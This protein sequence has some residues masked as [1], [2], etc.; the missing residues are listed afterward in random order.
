MEVT[1]TTENNNQSLDDVCVYNAKQY[2]DEFVGLK[3]EN[4][5]LTVQFPYGYRK[6]ESQKE[7]RKDILN[8]I[9]VLSSFSA[10]RDS[11]Y[12]EGNNS[13]KLKQFPIHSY[14]HIITSFMN[15]GYYKETEIVYKKNNTGKIS[16]N[17]TIKSVT[18]QLINDKSYY[19]D[20]ITRNINYNVSELITKIHEYIVYESFEKIGFLFCS[21]LPAKP[22][23]KFNKKLFTIIIK[24]KMAETFNERTLL[25]FKNM[26]DIIDYLDSDSENTNYY[27]GVNRFDHVWESMIN[28]VYGI[29]DKQNYYP[30]CYWN[31]NGKVIDFKDDDFRSTTLRPDTIMITGRNTPEQ[32]IFILDAKNYKYG[33]TPSTYNLPASDSIT[34]QLAYGDYIYKQECEGKMHK[35]K[36]IYNAFILPYDSHDTTGNVNPKLFGYASS[37]YVKEDE[38]NYY[39]I[40]GVLLDIKNL[41]YNHTAK[42]SKAIEELAK[43][44]DGKSL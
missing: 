18:P 13:K 9:S 1:E 35:S 38:R 2:G 8:L 29:D 14:I 11:Y 6:A 24:S 23:L 39:K 4:K 26:L 25:L 16:W 22:T 37:D 28:D 31:I 41:M 10:H 33:V 32:K 12:P 21:Y 36:E 19:F 44:I 43:I 42:N 3:Y 5:K 27:Y 15:Y 20:F 34:K 30:R 40:W 7:Q 17:K